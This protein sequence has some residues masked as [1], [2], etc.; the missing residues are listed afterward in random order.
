MKIGIK[1]SCGFQRKLNREQI[2]AEEKFKGEIFYKC[3]ISVETVCPLN[4]GD[5]TNQPLCFYC[6]PWGKDK[7]NKNQIMFTRE[8]IFRVTLT[9]L[10]GNG[11]PSLGGGVTKFSG[12]QGRWRDSKAELNR[13]RKWG[14]SQTNLLLLVFLFSLQEQTSVRQLYANEAFPQSYT[15]PR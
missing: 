10:L 9:K 8:S 6:H 11:G 1:I 14:K 7:G 3:V 4:D 13:R 5:L 2:L 15:G 12:F